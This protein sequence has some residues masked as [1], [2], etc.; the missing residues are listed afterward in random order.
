MKESHIALSGWFVLTLLLIPLSHIAVKSSTTCKKCNKSFALSK[1]G[2]EDIE[3]FV[4]YKRE[5]VRENGLQKILAIYE[6]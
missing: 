3:N 1:N 6:M 5:S 4:K 2:T